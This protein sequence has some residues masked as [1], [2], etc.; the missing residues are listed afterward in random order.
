M[1]DKNGIMKILPHRDPMLLIEEAELVDG[2]CIAKYTVRGDEFFLQGHF[3]NMPVVPGV[4]LCEMMA[5]GSCL[6]IDK[7]DD[8]ENYTPYF[9]TMDRVKFKKPVVPGD[10]IVLKSEVI[11]QKHPFY[12]VKSTAY[13]NNVL[14]AMGELSFALVK[15]S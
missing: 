2:I 6:L 10:C 8:G 12:F 14:C 4:I 13:V 7:K 11:K 9:T 3:P 5:Q 1:M 15:N